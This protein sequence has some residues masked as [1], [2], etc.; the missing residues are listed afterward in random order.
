MVDPGEGNLQELEELPRLPVVEGKP[1]VL[2][3]AGGHEVVDDDR[4]RTV[5][6]EVQVVRIGDVDVPNWL[7]GVL[8]D[9]GQLGAAHVVDV[10]AREI[11][12]RRDVLRAEADLES[13][14]DLE[15][16]RVDDR[17]VARVLVRDVD[18]RRQVGDARV[19]PA[20][21]GRGVDASHRG[22]SR[23]RLDGGLGR[24]LNGAGGGSW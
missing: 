15:G 17:H 13:A 23:R 14:D 24:G 4:L 3:V 6:R 2:E 19:D 16:L 18:P 8:V 7:R 9:D 10:E 22:W 5:E 20:V 21:D 12:V 11:P 1:V